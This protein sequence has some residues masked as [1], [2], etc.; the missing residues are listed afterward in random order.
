MNV[1]TVYCYLQTAGKP[2]PKSINKIASKPAPRWLQRVC[3][4]L[5]SSVLTRGNNGLLD[6]V[7][8]IMDVSSSPD[9]NDASVQDLKKFQLVAQIIAN[10]P[11]DLSGTEEDYYRLICPQVLRL[12]D[13]KDGSDSK[14]LHLISAACIR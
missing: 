1:L 8:G 9:G 7:R 2:V 10:P 5:L 4:R 13:I 14:A 12:L 6:V 3:G 11:K